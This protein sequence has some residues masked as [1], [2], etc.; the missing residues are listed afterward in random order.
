MIEAWRESRTGERINLVLL[1]G[2]LLVVLLF[3]G[4]SRADVLGQGVVRIA[5]LLLI[6]SSLLQIRSDTVRAVQAPLLFLLAFILIIALQL[7]PLPYDLWRGLSGREDFARLLEAGGIDP[8]S[9][10]LSITP[11]LTLNS[12]L[13]ALPPLAAILALGVLKRQFFPFV[14]TAV[15]VGI[16]I[17]AMIGVLQIS[18]GS[19]YFYRVTNIGSAVGAFANRNHQA[20]FVASAFPLLAAWAFISSREGRPSP[21]RMWVALAVAA[22]IFPLLLVTGSRGGLVLGVV[23]AAL[24]AIQVALGQNSRRRSK[25]KLISPRTIATLALPVFLVSAALLP[26]IYFSRTEALERIL[27]EDHANMRADYLPIYMDLISKFF[28]VGSGFGSFDAVFRANEPFWALRP[29]YLN[30][31]HNDLAELLIEGGIFGALL[32]AL[33]LGWHLLR[34][35]QLWLGRRTEGTPVLGRAGSA[36]VFMVLLASLVDYP[37]RTPIIAVLVAIACCCMSAEVSAG[38]ARK[39]G[40]PGNPG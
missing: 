18:S 25:R 32:F 15:L 6:A 20:L 35:A 28:P 34:S 8:V 29:Y 22:A 11:D 4:A 16:G 23:G 40:L 37:I 26:F 1:S 7:I 5:A 24:A 30:H 10:P 33:F 39:A 2:F 38:R 27:A 14:V 9:R 21:M 36:I 12:L 17:S 3:G 31:A 13:S 19:P